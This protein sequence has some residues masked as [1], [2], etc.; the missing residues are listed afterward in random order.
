[1]ATTKLPTRKLSD[2]T[3]AVIQSLQAGD[4]IKVTQTVRVG[5]KSWKAEAQ[6]TYRGLTYL[7]TGITTDRVPEDDIIVPL[8]QFTKANGEMGSIS[9]DENTVLER[10]PA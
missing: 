4:T 1:M 3:L 2:A 7:S 5:A 6:G 9:L 8:V 10:L